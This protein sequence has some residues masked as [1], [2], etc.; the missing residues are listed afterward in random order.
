MLASNEAAFK[1]QFQ[2][3]ATATKEI[4]LPKTH[5]ENP[6]HKKKNRYNNILPYDATRV[7]L[8]ETAENPD[9]INANYV[10]GYS[11]EHKFIATQGP[12]D[13]TTGDFWR[14]VW[15]QE[16]L[17]IVML[18][19]PVESGKTKCAKYWPDQGK[20]C[21]YDGYSVETVKE[22]DY[23][24]YIVRTINI[25]ETN[26]E[27]ATVLG[28]LQLFQYT[29]WPEE[30]VPLISTSLIQMQAKVNTTWSSLFNG[31]QFPIVVHGSAGAGR[32]GAYIG[33][34]IL[35]DEMES[36]DQVNVF[37]TVLNMRKQRMDMVQNMKQYIFLYKV[38]SECY[39][40]GN[41]GVK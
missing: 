26:N 15:E 24:S 8:K 5:A 20:R 34:D 9:Y 19:N 14:M 40:L 10:N 6:L 11:Q 2:E 23:G 36:K 35:L 7:C 37:R 21:R 3:L 4:K 41:T 29:E 30:D 27:Y 32:T 18:T 38:M 33:F 16:C 12:L 22:V 39:A 17:V 13:R 28:T 25:E 1:K 31:K